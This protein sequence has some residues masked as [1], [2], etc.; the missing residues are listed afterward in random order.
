MADDWGS[1]ADAVR[2]AME[3]HY[4]TKT[5]FLREAGL[6]NKPV[7]ALLAGRPVS[8]RTLR[9]VERALGWPPRTA[10]RILRGDP[11]RPQED[12]ES[13]ESTTDEEV[14]IRVRSD[15]ERRLAEQFRDMLEELRFG[16]R[17]GLPAGPDERQRGAG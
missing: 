14:V 15:R 13:S 17:P 8:A 4:D 3:R 2:D 6:T 5:A 11:I 16:E 10:D 9:P 12:D 1:L 7:D